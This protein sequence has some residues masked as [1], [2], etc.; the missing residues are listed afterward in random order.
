MFCRNI[1]LKFEKLI[2]FILVISVAYPDPG[3][4]AFLTPESGQD[5]KKYDQDPG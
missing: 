2:T 1:Y 3:Y 4:G 5:G